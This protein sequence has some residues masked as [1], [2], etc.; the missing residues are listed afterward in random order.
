MSS[1]D[2]DDMYNAFYYVEGNV[3]LS[4]S[5]EDAFWYATFVTEGYLEVSGNGWFKPWGTHPDQTTGNEIA[6]NILYWAGND[7]KINGNPEQKF[8][9]VIATHMDVQVS[10]NPYFEATIVAENGLYHDGQEVRSGQEVKNIVDNNQFNSSNNEFNG[11]MVL[12]SS[13]VTPLHAAKK[14]SVT[15]WRELV[16]L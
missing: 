14:L 9:G 6:D 15:A 10:G 3:V 16:T 4:G 11:N 12:N 7:L 5:P 1:S 13:G 2:S 8:F